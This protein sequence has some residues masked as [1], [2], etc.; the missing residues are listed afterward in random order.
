[1]YEVIGYELLD[2][3]RDADASLGED[4]LST[5]AMVKGRL[6]RTGHH[7]V[8]T[9]SASLSLA[10]IGGRGREQLGFLGKDDVGFGP[11]KDRLLKRAPR[12]AIAGFNGPT[13]ALH[14]P[15]VI[16]LNNAKRGDSVRR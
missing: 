15:S 4:R 13:P 11:L 16:D 10:S 6:V 3:R 8:P 9:K 7:R 5:R 1:M 12:V 2:A 14:P